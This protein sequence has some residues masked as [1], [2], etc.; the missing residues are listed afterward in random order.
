MKRVLLAAACAVLP[1]AVFAPA[2]SQ[3]VEV[4]GRG[5]IEH[6]A[7]LRRLVEAGGYTLIADDTIIARGDTVPGPVLVAGATLRVDGVIAGDLVI[8]DAN[9]FLRPTARVLGG[10]RNVGGGFYPSEQAD[11]AGAIHSAANAPY[12]VE[13]GDGTISIVG[14]TQRSNVVRYGFQGVLLPTYDRVEALSVGLGA[15]LLLPRAGRVEPE[16]RGRVEYRTRRGEFGGAL[17]LVGVRGGTQLIAGAERTTA[18]NERWIRSDLV[19]TLNSLVQAKDRR[20]YYEADRAYVELRRDL[21]RGERS[22]TAFLRGQVEDA[23][24]LQAGD[25]WSMFGSFRGDNI[26]FDESRI[27]SVIAGIALHWTRP[28]HVLQLETAVEAAGAVLDGEHA[29]NRYVVDIDWAM[30]ALANHTLRVQPYFQ[31]PLPGTERLPGQRWSF[32]GGSGTLYTFRDAEFRGDRVALVKTRYSIPFDPRLRVR[33]LGLPR[34]E[35]LHLAGMAWTADERRSFEQ[36]IGAQLSF[37]FVNVRVVTHPDRLSDDLEVS[38]GLSLP[39]RR[40]P[41]HED[42]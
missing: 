15:G 6:D 1:L 17:E 7:F 30:A 2:Q 23:R 13:R 27:S 8:V 10:V 34:L 20:D 25:P 24:P 28:T 37:T 29:F 5:D 35:L 14:L 38:F 4:R 3:V 12:R 42:R 40:Y 32:V 26:E 19:N 31:G 21:E 22:S 9:V 41:W 16:L 11:V 36:N 18:T 39:P 33:I